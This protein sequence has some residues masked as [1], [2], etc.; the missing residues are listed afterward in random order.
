[1]RFILI[2]L[3]TLNL[4][5]AKKIALLIGNKNYSFAPLSNPLNDIKVIKKALIDIG[6]KSKNIMLL[7]NATKPQIDTALYNF[8]LEAESAKIA[9]VYFSGHGLQVGGTNYLMPTQVKARSHRD[10]VRLV[11]LDRVIDTAGVAEAGVVLIDACR[12][13]PLSE[14]F[15]VSNSKS[16]NGNKGLAQITAK[17][18]LKVIVGF[19]TQSGQVAQ[20]G[21]GDNSPYAMALQSALKLNRDITKVLGAVNEDVLS[22]TGSQM[23]MYRSTLGRK[24]VCLTG[25]CSQKVITDKSDELARLRAENRRLKKQERRESLNSKWITPTQKKASWEKAKKICR[26]NGG[27]LPTVKE[28][29]QV[30]TDCGG[31]VN[32]DYS[33]GKKNKEN[34]NYQN[35]YKKKGFKSDDDYWSSTTNVNGTY[36]AWIVSFD[37]GH[38]DNY[39]KAFSHYVRCVRAG[40]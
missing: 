39:T 17:R 18:G 7:K 14:N 31:I 21:R 36:V 12:D 3:L 5:S 26:A 32:A 27:R 35:C 24:D 10:L 40:Q 25:S 15:R 33:E 11:N 8:G 23:P 20:D 34:I 16:G 29:N 37:Y 22:A 2:F 38:Q 9:L 6:F 13:N 1:M 19:A 4:L 30:I 28:L